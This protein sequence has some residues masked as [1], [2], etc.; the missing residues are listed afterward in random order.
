MECGNRMARVVP[1]CKQ[2]EVDVLQP[3]NG[4]GRGWPDIVQCDA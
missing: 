3:G 2:A 4:C 1:L